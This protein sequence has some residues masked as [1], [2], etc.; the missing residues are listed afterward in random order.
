MRNNER[1]PQ[2]DIQGFEPL[3][4]AMLLVAVAPLK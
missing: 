2:Y 4:E 1:G 3:K